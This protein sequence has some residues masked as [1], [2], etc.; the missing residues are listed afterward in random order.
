MSDDLNEYF[1]GRTPLTKEVAN[2]IVE[3]T[4]VGR[5]NEQRFTGSSEVGS[6]GL[7]AGGT[8]LELGETPGAS[9]DAIAVAEAGGTSM[10]PSLGG[11]VSLIQ[12]S[13]GD[14]QGQITWPPYRFVLEVIAHP[15]TGEMV[16]ATHTG[17]GIELTSFP[18]AGQNL[19]YDTVHG[20]DPTRGAYSQ[21]GLWHSGGRRARSS[22]L[23]YL[24]FRGSPTG[25]TYRLGRNDVWTDPLSYAA[26]Q[27]EIQ[28]A[29]RTLPDLAGTLVRGSINGNY[30]NEPFL[31]AP[32]GDGLD[33]LLEP[34]ALAVDSNLTG[35]ADVLGGTP[36]VFCARVRVGRSPGCVYHFLPL[37]SLDTFSSTTTGGTFRLRWRGQ[38]TVAIP[39]SR[40]GWVTEIA[41]QAALESLPL[42]GP[43]QVIV[44]VI[45][46]S[47][48]AL[49]TQPAVP[50]W[51]RGADSCAVYGWRV[52]F[53]GGDAE[54]VAGAKSLRVLTTGLTPV[55]PA[56]FDVLPS[57]ERWS[58]VEDGT[59]TSTGGEFGDLPWG[60]PG[61]PPVPYSGVPTYL[62]F[63]GSLAPVLTSQAYQQ[64]V[65]GHLIWE[66]GYPGALY[67]TVIVG[68]Y[69]PEDSDFPAPLT[70]L[71]SEL[72]YDGSFHLGASSALDNVGRPFTASG[73]FLPLDDLLV[74]SVSP[75]G[76]HS[77]A[78]NGY[79]NQQAAS[80][81]NQRPSLDLV[82]ITQQTV[83]TID[84]QPVAVADG[85][86]ERPRTQ[87]ASSGGP[88]GNQTY[89]WLS[90]NDDLLFDVGFFK[91]ITANGVPSFSYR[92]GDEA[93]TLA[94][95]VGVGVVPGM[96]ATLMG[97]G[98]FIR[99]PGGIFDDTLHLDP[100]DGLSQ[101]GQYVGGAF[102][103]G[104]ATGVGHG[105]FL[106][107]VGP[108]APASPR[109]PAREVA[110]RQLTYAGRIGSPPIQGFVRDPAGVQASAPMAPVIEQRF[111][112]LYASSDDPLTSGYVSSIHRTALS[113][114]PTDLR[115][116][117]VGYPM[118]LRLTARP[119]RNH[120][121]DSP[122]C[123]AM[124]SGIDLDS[125]GID[126]AGLLGYGE[127]PESLLEL[128]PAGNKAVT[129]VS[130]LV[131]SGSV[132][133]QG[134][135][136][137]FV[138]S[139]CLA[140]RD[141]SDLSQWKVGSDGHLFCRLYAF[142]NAIPSLPLP[143]HVSV[144]V[145]SN[146]PRTLS[147]GAPWLLHPGM[148]GVSNV[149]H[150]QRP[151]ARG[152]GSWEFTMALA[153]GP[154]DFSVRS[155]ERSAPEGWTFGPALPDGGFDFA[156]I[157]MTPGGVHALD[158]SGRSD[159][160]FPPAGGI[161]MGRCAT[162]SALRLTL[163]GEGSLLE[164]FRSSPLEETWRSPHCACW[165]LG[166]LAHMSGATYLA[167]L[168]PSA[169]GHYEILFA[170]YNPDSRDGVAPESAPP[171]NAGWKWS[172]PALYVPLN[173]R[174]PA[175][176][177][178]TGPLTWNGSCETF[179]CAGIVRLEEPGVGSAIVHVHV[180]R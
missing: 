83:V 4:R 114:D 142:E 122:L 109:Q 29:V 25:G 64:R 162:L 34:G 136:T 66:M 166:N 98:D 89:F 110:A 140:E 6:R 41:M 117:N 26:G 115:I 173:A 99:N 129:F 138:L 105:P 103:T 153:G 22:Y 45:P 150:L 52:H 111:A 134:V 78:T 154:V 146:V 81:R 63:A 54:I 97:N 75:S 13:E 17:R 11:G 168:M 60:I 65:P 48:P 39:L 49:F 9:L 71:G 82:R 178:M 5:T 128:A 169:D 151:V 100:L 19:S 51:S 73:A 18:I 113:D 108:P 80:I 76:G 35:D 85:Y 15:L 40:T 170:R 147:P 58:S 8:S 10:H 30:G 1:D 112:G 61:N 70:L 87:D 132:T 143:H 90:Q 43:G 123:Q 37:S 59:F 62:A 149:S 16:L 107:Y 86:L 116:R 88:Y 145:R 177:M 161:I 68:T 50:Y 180:T 165:R 172:G 12:S 125:N 163:D 102:L 101:I 171:M 23:Y 24:Y 21:P 84:G 133:H 67:S 104:P 46:S 126:V 127:A 42:V 79:A 28:A 175:D 36:S 96:V 72:S 155:A 144:P 158:Y 91:Q 137:W 174:D 124:E 120:P 38:T 74:T 31:I 69:V 135:T 57:I 148:V 94:A 106:S 176:G 130:G 121:G 77:M 92:I 47:T 152:A 56:D 14:G 33:V 55:E 93:R 167:L 2:A 95:R 131:W 118:R 141:G 119:G 27:A 157:D 164:R 7:S 156:R 179:T 3:A 139:A 159:Q 44:T 53:L 32:Q 20:I 160:P